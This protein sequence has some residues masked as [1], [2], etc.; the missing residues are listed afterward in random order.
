[1]PILRN[2]MED[3][4]NGV[5]SVC[6]K[7]V[8]GSFTVQE[9]ESKDGEPFIIEVAGTPDRDFN[10]CDA[11]NDLVHYRCSKHP[12]TGYCDRCFEKYGHQD[13]SVPKPSRQV[14]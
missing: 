14:G 5:C 2:T 10:V 7:P 12:E 1:M 4:S 8:R 3:N 11:C 6:E 13:E 9:S